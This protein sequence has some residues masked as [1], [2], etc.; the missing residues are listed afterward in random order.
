MIISEYD[1]REPAGL[2]IQLS[3]AT[4]RERPLTFSQTMTLVD[5]LARL[6]LKGEARKYALGYLWWIVEPMLFVAIFYIVFE[7]LL[8]NRHP[9]FLYFLMVG[10]LVFIW[11]SKSV[12]QAANSI[13]SNKGLMAQL[14]LRKE[15]LPLAVI[16]Q[17]LYRQ[18]VVFGF[19]LIFLAAVGYA[20]TVTWWWLV[21]VVLIQIML[22]VAC[23][24]LAALLVCF[25]RDFLLLVQL[26]IVFLLFMSGIFWDVNAIPDEGLRHWLLILNPLATLIDYYRQILL[27]GAVP[28]PEPLVRVLLQAVAL[29]GVAIFAYHRLQFWI[30]RQVISR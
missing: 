17:G 11:F 15:I 27:S 8:Q 6:H 22:T 30:A 3:I 13:E 25:Q 24:L 16:H 5:T 19:L 2:T 29:L 9:D 4:T 20:V 7:M 14:N 23:G 26:G 10:K 28:S 18:L 21:P 12:S 1:A